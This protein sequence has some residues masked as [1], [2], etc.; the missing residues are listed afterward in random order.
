MNLSI[1]EPLLSFRQAQSS[2]ISDAS[3]LTSDKG[4]ETTMIAAA[5]K[6]RLF[7]VVFFLNLVV[8]VIG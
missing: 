3:A 1:Y 4:S 6:T 2:T 7:G 8:S 5:H